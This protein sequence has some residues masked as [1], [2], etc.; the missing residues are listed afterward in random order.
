MRSP[1]TR[2]AAALVVLAIAP[3]C[4]RVS[5]RS[6]FE[7]PEETLE[8][9]ASAPRPG[10]LGVDPTIRV[11]LCLSGRIDPRSVDE[12]DATISSGNSVMD[13][14]LSVQ[15]V[16]W[17]EP[18]LDEPPVDTREPWCSGSVLS[19]K[20]SIPLPSGAL[21][22]LRMRPSA[23][24]WE[25]ES[26]STEGPLWLAI[27]E[28]DE[29]RYLLEFTT[30]PEPYVPPQPPDEPPPPPLLTLTDLFSSGGPFDPARDKCSCHRDPDH[31]ALARLDLRD[32]TLAYSGLLDSAEI[33]DTGFPMIAPRDPSQSF[34]IQKLL[35][36]DG[37]ALHGILGDP[38]PPEAP[39]SYRDL[40]WIV[41]WIEDGAAP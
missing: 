10:A 30:D 17:L 24:G 39:L 31:L 37:E 11:D 7:G 38:M 13:A 16:P 4:T 9:L 2:W 25:G 14:E 19:V 28:G 3:A 29:P 12:V 8:I 32:P 26:L 36:E 27:N 34:L 33:R 23:V 40:L 18:G 6:R 41:R 20:P 35:R 21:V 15:L 22:R 1:V 5:D